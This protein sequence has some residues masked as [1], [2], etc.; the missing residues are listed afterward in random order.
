MVRFSDWQKHPLW[1]GR[2]L[3]L[4]PSKRGITLKGAKPWITPQ[5]PANLTKA[6]LWKAQKETSS[7]L[8]SHHFLSLFGVTLIFSPLQPDSALVW[9]ITHTAKP[10]TW[11][12]LLTPKQENHLLPSSNSH[13]SFNRHLPSRHPH[14]LCTASQDTCTMLGQSSKQT[15]LSFCASPTHQHAQP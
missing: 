3:L 6:C 2:D 5:I 14:S 15:N 8:T 11:C 4:V 12:L 9:L 1:P 13:S 7:K 10:Q